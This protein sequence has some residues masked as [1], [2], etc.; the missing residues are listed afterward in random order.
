MPRKAV[1]PR[2]GHLVTVTVG[3]PVDVS[4]L[5]P[6]CNCKGEDQAQV[7]LVALWELCL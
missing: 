1:V 6:R 5:T 7:G 3:N 4:D 2:S